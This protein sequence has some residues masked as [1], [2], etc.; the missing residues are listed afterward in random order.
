MAKVVEER[1]FFWWF[2]EPDLPAHSKE[3]S[4]PAL[5]VITDDGQITLD[6]E[7]S[8]SGNDEHRDWNKSRNLSALRRIAGLLASP[9]EYV[10]LE[11]LE[12]TDFSL[13]DAS[14]QQQAFTAQSCTRRDLA[15][16]ETY[17]DDD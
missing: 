1:G 11:G 12:R 17:G 2:N 5:L 7:G 6:V 8:L 14:P 16:A 13:D 9:N 4:V 3:T 10:L 15:F